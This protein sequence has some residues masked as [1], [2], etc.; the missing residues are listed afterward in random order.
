M[1]MDRFHSAIVFFAV[2]S[3]IIRDGDIYEEG[4]FFGIY[5]I[6]STNVSNYL[7]TLY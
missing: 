5:F 2:W 7:R 1:D 3:V 4:V 6:R